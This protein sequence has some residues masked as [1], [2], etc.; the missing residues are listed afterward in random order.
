MPMSGAAGWIWWHTRR[1]YLW[2]SLL[3]YY[4]C[5][6]QHTHLIVT[7]RNYVGFVFSLCEQGARCT[8]KVT[9]DIVF[10]RIWCG[11]CKFKCFEHFMRAWYATSCHRSL[12]PILFG[13]ISR[14]CDPDNKNQQQQELSARKWADWSNLMLLRFLLR[15]THAD[16]RFQ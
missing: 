8:L 15:C 4:S 5:S 2:R 13:C 12:S 7:S 9:D 3:K 10:C 11:V 6:P 16:E 14:S 1:F